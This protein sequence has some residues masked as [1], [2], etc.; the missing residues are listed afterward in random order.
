MSPKM[1]RLLSK[2]KKLLK[3]P[4]Q[5]VNFVKALETIKKYKD[6]PKT[7]R[8]KLGIFGMTFLDDVI[9][10]LNDAFFSKFLE[11]LLVLYMN[12]Q[13][14]HSTDTESISKYQNRL[15]VLQ[16]NLALSKTRSDR[17]LDETKQLLRDTDEKIEEMEESLK[18][19]LENLEQWINSVHK[20]KE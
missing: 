13:Y 5:R 19:N 7:R 20:K 2:I 4:V 11:V 6:N 18:F 3:N 12:R 8:R 9:P 1:I 17:K 16:D 15:N 10:I 14:H